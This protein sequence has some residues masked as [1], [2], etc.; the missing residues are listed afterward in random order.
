MGG[1]ARKPSPA[2]SAPA[3]A[4]E[5]SRAGSR[6]GQGRERPGRRNGPGT[7]KGAL[8]DADPAYPNGPA[9]GGITPG[10]PDLSVPAWETGP[11]PAAPPVRQR[12]PAVAH[13]EGSAG[14]ASRL[15]PLGSGLV[16]IGLGLG[17]AL[18]ALRLRRSQRAQQAG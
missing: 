9:D 17:L 3:P 13:A 14:P 7:E 16:L 6:P 2:R 18:F 1:T 10:R 15:L 4:A 5:P 8:T 12:E 11:G